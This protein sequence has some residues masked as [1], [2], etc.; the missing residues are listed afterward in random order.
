MAVSDVE[1]ALQRWAAQADEAQLDAGPTLADLG[2]APAVL[3][4][5]DA[6]AR[7]PQ[8]PYL[9]QAM[10]QDASGLPGPEP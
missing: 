8:L 5:A 10:A 7:G 6:L 4:E 9:L 1:Q 2:G 3:R